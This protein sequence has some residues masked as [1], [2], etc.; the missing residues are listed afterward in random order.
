MGLCMGH[1][2]LFSKYSQ[3]PITTLVVKDRATYHNPVTTLVERHWR[4]KLFGDAFRS[5]KDGAFLA[6]PAV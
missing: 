1:D 5:E 4:Y 3:A 6:C 2:I